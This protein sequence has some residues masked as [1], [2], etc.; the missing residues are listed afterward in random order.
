[1]TDQEIYSV[2]S[3]VFQ[4]VF[5]RDD[6]ALTPDLTAKDVKGWD[7]FKQIEIVYTV[8]ERFSIKLNAREIEALKSVGDLAA[9]IARKTA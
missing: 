6:I 7:S 3:E 1:M 5:L 9:V 2:L 8:E 4:D